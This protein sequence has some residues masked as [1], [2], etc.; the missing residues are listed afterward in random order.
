[1]DFCG[2]CRAFAAQFR[3][4]WRAAFSHHSVFCGSFLTVFTPVREPERHGGVQHHHPVSDPAATQQ[5]RYILH[6]AAV[7]HPPA[8]YARLSGQSECGALCAFELHGS[9]CAGV[10]PERPVRAKGLLRLRHDLRVPGAPAAH[11]GGI[12]GSDAVPAVLYAGAHRGAAPLCPGCL[13]R[14]PRRR[15]RSPGA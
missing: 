3:S 2:I 1:M 7:H 13:P 4:R 14:P 15:R 9:L 6:Q 5:H 11:A 10:F 12:S 8:G